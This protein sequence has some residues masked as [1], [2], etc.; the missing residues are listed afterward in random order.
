MRG[1][2]RAIMALGLVVVSVLPALASPNGVWELETRDTRIQL[3]LCG[4]GTQLCGM[5]VWL[6]DADYNQQ[7][8][9]YLNTPVANKMRPAG[10]NRWKGAL[11]LF[12]YNMSG[13]ITQNS[14]DHMTLSGCAFLVVCKTYQMYRHDK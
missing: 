11:Q 6:S 12:G 3:Q 2:S 5:L 14:A 8:Q 9:R 10:P 4:D 13:T 1:F 7:Y